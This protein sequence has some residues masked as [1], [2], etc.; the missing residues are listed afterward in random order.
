MYLKNDIG[1]GENVKVE[2]PKQIMEQ[3][4]VCIEY[5]EHNFACNE[6]SIGTKY[7]SFKV[8]NCKYL[9]TCDEE[10]I[11]WLVKKF[12]KELKKKNSK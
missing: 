10:P 11:A 9:K 7:E 5:A 8:P 1:N 3:F 6:G 2:I 4:L 12:Q